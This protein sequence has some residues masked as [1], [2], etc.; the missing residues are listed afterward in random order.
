MVV[1]K[2]IF[3]DMVWEIDFYFGKWDCCNL[4]VMIGF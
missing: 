4:Y 3:N 2:D 1:I